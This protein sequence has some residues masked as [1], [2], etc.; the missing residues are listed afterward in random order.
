MVLFTLRNYVSISPD[1]AG[2]SFRDKLTK[3]GQMAR[4]FLGRPAEAQAAR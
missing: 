1:Y 4:D 3:A 2:L